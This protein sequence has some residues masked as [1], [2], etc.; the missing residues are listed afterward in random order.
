MGQD[1]WKESFSNVSSL[2]KKKQCNIS[3]HVPIELILSD[4]AVLASVYGGPSAVA[5]EDRAWILL[6]DSSPHLELSR[7]KYEKLS[8]HFMYQE[9]LINFYIKELI[10]Q[11]H[12]FTFIIDILSNKI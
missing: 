2:Q 7:S 5:V 3:K 9:P 11:P 12:F 8:I 10:I 4:G 1:C 6:G